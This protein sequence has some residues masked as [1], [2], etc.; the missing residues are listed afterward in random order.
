MTKEQAQEDSAI[1]EPADMAGEELSDEEIW[2]EIANGAKDDD[3]EPDDDADP[4]DEAPDDEGAEPEPKGDGNDDD[5]DDPE[6]LKQQIE[7]L[8]QQ[9][10]SEKGRARGLNMKYER[11]QS[12]LRAAKAQVEALR[13]AETDDATRKQL[14]KAREEYGDVLNPVLSRQDKMDESN[15]R[16]TKAAEENVKT[17]SAEYSEL[18]K[19][20]LDVFLQEHPK[21]VDFLRENHEQFK[22]WV[23]DQ[24]K[25]YRDIYN[26]NRQQ[27]V[28]GAS[29]ALLLSQFKAHIA[30]ANSTGS[31]PASTQST[32]RRQRQLA[33]AQSVRAASSQVV[34]SDNVPSGDDPEALWKYW[35]RKKGR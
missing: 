33:G 16:L 4:V 24:P 19:E 34:T 7:K 18:A 21:G 32:S 3:L 9:F 27:I 26:A 14:Q 28:D 6:K 2:N 22:A 10:N 20:Q 12:Q 13:F 29:S 17:I 1:R 30:A 25:Q 11:L 8:T 5:S 15:R 35:A 31:R 23:E